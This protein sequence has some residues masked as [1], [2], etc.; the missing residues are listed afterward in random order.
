MAKEGIFNQ[1]LQVA[2]VVKDLDESMK[3]YWTS[4]ALGL[5]RSIHLIP[6]Q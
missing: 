3:N 4:G 6:I 5:G 1:V 2:V